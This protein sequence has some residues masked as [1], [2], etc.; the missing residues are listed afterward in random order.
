MVELGGQWVGPTLRAM[1]LAGELGLE[2]YPTYSEGKSVFENPAGRL[3]RYTGTIPRMNPLVLADYGAD[4]RPAHVQRVDPRALGGGE[5]RGARQ[6]DLRDLDQALGQDPDG[7]RGAGAGDP[8]RVLGRAGRPQSASSST[9][10]ARAAGTSCWRW[11]GAQQDRVVGGSQRISL[12]MA[13]ELGERCSSRP[14]SARS[15][16]T[17][18][19]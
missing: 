10:P 18:R 8:G 7:P 11:K 14:W 1:A 13:D 6:R 3:S 5:G 19:R 9:R 2:T 17:A 4:A 15:A 12:G 16:W